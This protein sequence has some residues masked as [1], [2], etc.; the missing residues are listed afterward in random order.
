MNFTEKKKNERQVY[1]G[2]N[3]TK[4]NPTGRIGL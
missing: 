2:K 4:P 1:T 3:Q